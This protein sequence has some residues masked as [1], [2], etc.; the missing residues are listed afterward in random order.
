M[1]IRPIAKKK[2]LAQYVIPNCVGDAEQTLWHDANTSLVWYAISSSRNQVSLH[3]PIFI[4]LAD[5]S[6]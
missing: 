6:K 4:Y 3:E 2:L 5:N 1:I